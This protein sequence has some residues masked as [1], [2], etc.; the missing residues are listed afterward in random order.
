MP[1]VQLR[2]RLAVGSCPQGKLL[3]RIEVSR[4]HRIDCKP[5]NCLHRF[6]FSLGDQY[7]DNG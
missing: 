2:E 5:R 6:L 1:A 4:F 7:T 3:R